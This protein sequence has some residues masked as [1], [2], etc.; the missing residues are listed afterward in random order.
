MTNL[1]TIVME[2]KAADTL[3]QAAAV[4][5]IFLTELEFRAVQAAKTSV[6]PSNLTVTKL[7]S[8]AIERLV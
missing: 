7:L 2:R 1:E 8:D 3:M 6:E 4:G 5:D